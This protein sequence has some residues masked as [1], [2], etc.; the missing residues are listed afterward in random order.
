MGVLYDYFRAPGAAAAATAA[1]RPGGPLATA[2]AGVAFDGVAARGIDPVVTLGQ[3]V[4][5]VR[6][7]SWTPEL[8]G[9]EEIAR[10]AVAGAW[11][12]RLG[13]PVRDALAGAVDDT[14]PEIVV[15][16]SQ[17][18][19]FAPGSDTDERMLFALVTDLVGLA[20][21]ARAAN[22]QLYCWCCL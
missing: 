19:E 11:V 13:Q 4:A 5:F 14:L 21:R 1:Q 6:G 15:K 9:A 18:E 17:T 2:G 8:V 10:S 3:L 16:W 12:E 7:V 20:R 22:E